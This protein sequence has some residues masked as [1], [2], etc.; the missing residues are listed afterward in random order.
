MTLTTMS[1]ASSRASSRT[2]TLGAQVVSL[3]LHV[4]VLALLMLPAGVR[5]SPIGAEYQ[6]RTVVFVPPKDSPMS[7]TKPRDAAETG[8]E[9]VGPVDSYPGENLSRDSTTERPGTNID[10]EGSRL[11]FCR[12]D[13]QHL[14]KVLAQYGGRLALTRLA[15]PRMVEYTAVPPGWLLE[16]DQAMSLDEGVPF[17]IYNAAAY[18]Q[19]KTLLQEAPHDDD[20][21][22]YA[23]FPPSFGAA[24]WDEVRRCAATK[25]S[26]GTRILTVTLCFDSSNPAGI[27]VLEMT[28]A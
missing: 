19:V 10:I 26:V 12:D 1:S 14:I 21:L 8:Q 6:L 15:T 7:N 2:R 28:T 23:V 13:A 17:L 20:L 3:C 11:V 22:V 4:L 18:G 24:M 25:Y 9:L 27:S 5:E 16:H